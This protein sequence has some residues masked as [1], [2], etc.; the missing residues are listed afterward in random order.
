MIHAYLQ[1]VFSTQKQVLEL[2]AAAQRNAL[3]EAHRSKQVAQ[4][5]LRQTFDKYVQ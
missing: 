1:F 3:D 4:K 2:Q 5:Y